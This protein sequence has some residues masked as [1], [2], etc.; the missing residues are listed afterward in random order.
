MKPSG[1]GLFFDGRL[2]ITPCIID[3]LIGLLRLSVSS[4]FTLD[5]LYVSK[6]LSVS[7]SFSNLLANIVHRSL[8]KSLCISAIMGIVAEFQENQGNLG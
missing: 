6:N 1:C 2:S 8:F 5:R 7:S 4:W 3:S